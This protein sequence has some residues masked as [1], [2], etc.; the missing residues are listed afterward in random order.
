[1]PRF[2]TINIRR[3]GGVRKKWAKFLNPLYHGLSMVWSTKLHVEIMTMN[4]NIEAHSNFERL[5]HIFATEQINLELHISF[6]LGSQ[7]F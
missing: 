6:L 5:I 2:N 1:M 3:G 4:D 7:K